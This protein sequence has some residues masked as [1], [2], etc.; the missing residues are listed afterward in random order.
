MS[1]DCLT[2]LSA[3]AKKRAA[4]TARTLAH[5]VDPVPRPVLRRL[6]PPLA[7]M[8]VLLTAGAA[9]L[10]VQLHQGQLAA[11]LQHLAALVSDDLRV[12]LAEQVSLNTSPIMM[13]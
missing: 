1:D 5:P 11:N 4:W 2:A 10:L 12:S 9:L 8:V 7:A 13:R 3:H 6:L